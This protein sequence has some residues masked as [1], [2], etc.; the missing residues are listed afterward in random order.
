MDRQQLTKDLQSFSGNPC[1]INK[2]QLR[3]FTGKGK[4]ACTNL[5]EG[6]DFEEV[7]NRKNYFIKDVANKMLE[8][9][10]KGGR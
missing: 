3:K 10:V 6:L 5:L 9:T 1:F 4:M 7:G 8:K 2:S